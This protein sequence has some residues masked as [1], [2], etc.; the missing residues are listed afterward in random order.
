MWCFFY[1]PQRY[2]HSPFIQ[3]MILIL[4]LVRLPHSYVKWIGTL[5]DLDPRLTEALRYI[6]EGTWSY[7]SGSLQH[8]DLLTNYSHELG[9]PSAWGDPNI[10][11]PY[12]G[13]VANATWKELGL[14]GRSGVGGLPCDIVHGRVGS[15]LNLSNSCT[16]NVT[17]RSVTAFLEAIAIYLPV[18]VECFHR[19]LTLTPLSM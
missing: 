8:A 11:P 7:I 5:A 4:S 17:L 6:R 10:L 13:A 14:T 19:G 16:T 2:I 9:H 3:I 1:E 18:R 15:S 12:G